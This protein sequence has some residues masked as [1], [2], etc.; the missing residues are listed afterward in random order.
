MLFRKVSALGSL[1]RLVHLVVGR[2]LFF[3]ELK[4]VERTIAVDVVHRGVLLH[5]PLAVA[6]LQLQQLHSL[7]GAREAGRQAV[8]H[9]GRV[10][11]PPKK[12][13]AALRTAAGGV[14]VVAHDG[15]GLRHGP[16][17]CR[18]HP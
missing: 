15:D 13:A 9:R 11:P 5:D 16:R 12:D 14:L 1:E 17:V 4:Q 2:D 10:C 7:V 3:L 6:V 8:R 18:C